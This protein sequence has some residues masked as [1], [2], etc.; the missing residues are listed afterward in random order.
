MECFPS[1]TPHHHTTMGLFRAVPFTWYIMFS[2]QEKITR[3]PK[4]QKP[5]DEYQEQASEADMAEMLE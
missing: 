4:T 1:P 5:Q 2:Y 3:H